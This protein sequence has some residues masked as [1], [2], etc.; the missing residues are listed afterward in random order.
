[1]YSFV[2]ALAVEF[3]PNQRWKEVDISTVPTSTFFTKY[4]QMYVV[5]TNSFIVDEMTL[6]LDDVAVDLQNNVGTISDY[7][8]ANGN[9]TLPTVAGTPVIVRNNVIFSDAFAAGFMVDSIDYTIGAGVDLPQELK[10]HLIVTPED[11]TDTYDYLSLRSKVL[12]NVNSFYH[13]T[14]ADS[15]GYYIID[16]NKSRL[17]SKQNY[18]GLLSFGTLGE[19]DI[20]PITD[21]ML[22][23]DINPDTNQVDQVHI[24]FTDCDLCVKTPILFLGGYMLMADNQYSLLTNTNIFTFKTLKY[25][26][27]ERYFE[28]RD[29][30]DFSAF[31][32]VHT[33][34]N[35]D[36]VQ[37]SVFKSEAYLRKYFTMSNSFMVMVD[38][39]NMVIEKTYPE[40]QTVPHTFMHYSGQ[41]EPPKWPLV[42]A[43]GKHEIYWAQYE[44]N[45]WVLRCND[46][47]KRRYMFQTTATEDLMAIDNNLFLGDAGYYSSAY[48]LKLI[49]EEIQIKTT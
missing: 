10:P 36:W 18:V 32:P 9:K 29:Y 7:L 27:P 24:K 45:S 20:H 6:N 31:D 15:K 19:L 44:A 28:S 17:K 5:L 34:D 14:A 46:T 21:D 11:Q 26:F 3:G 4:K 22:A 49:A 35:P 30:L 13:N 37:L 23:F 47:Y 48:F 2:R 40:L 1:M 33:N 12:A 41:H 38:T 39:T 16:G 42:V 8:S 25:P 43:D